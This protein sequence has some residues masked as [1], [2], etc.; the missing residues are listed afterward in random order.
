MSQ[1]LLKIYICSAYVS[2]GILPVS[3]KYQKCTKA[4]SSSYTP[5]RMTY[6]SGG[7]SLSAR[8]KSSAWTY[9]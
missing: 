5:L 4:R 9:H 6:V 7:S 3:F 2:N 1:P 8:Q